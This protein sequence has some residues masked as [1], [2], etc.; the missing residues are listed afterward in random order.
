MYTLA[1]LSSTRPSFLAKDGCI[2]PMAD[3][4][5]LTYECTTVGPGTTHWRGTAFSCSG[6]GNEISLRH[7]QFGTSGGTSG[8]C[9]SGN[10]TGRSLGVEGS[11]Y[12]SQLF[13][14]FSADLLGRSVMCVHDN[15]V[16]EVVIGNSTIAFTTGIVRQW[17]TVCI[18][19][20]RMFVL[21]L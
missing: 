21:I 16:T 11:C 7:S 20:W 10:I 3:I 9:N 8:E 19:V 18:T 4:R 15:L 6:Q 12:M 13:V 14:V 2:C 17:L 1:G 5:N